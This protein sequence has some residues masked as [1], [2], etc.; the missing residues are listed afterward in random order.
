MSPLCQAA[1]SDVYAN[2][3]FVHFFDLKLFLV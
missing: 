3:L 1:E 2:K